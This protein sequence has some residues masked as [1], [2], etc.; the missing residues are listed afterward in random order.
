MSD[1]TQN[2][3]V[4]VLPGDLVFTGPE[5]QIR[6]PGKLT[7]Q[8]ITVSDTRGGTEGWTL[9]TSFVGAKQIRTALT[10]TVPG[11]APGLTTTAY[12]IDPVT[13][14]SKDNQI[15]PAEST[16]GSWMLD[17]EVEFPDN[18]D[19]VNYALQPFMLI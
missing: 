14:A 13:I 2:V 19:V 9:T 1:S 15:G 4:S 6:Q 18:V 12:G 17:V 11:S 16:G 5:K 3:N 10:K 7:L 8:G